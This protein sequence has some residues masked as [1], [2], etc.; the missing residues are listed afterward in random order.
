MLM[1]KILLWFEPGFE[2]KEDFFSKKPL[3]MAVDS[4]VLSG[5]D[6]LI[7][8]R[9]SISSKK[10][11]PDMSLITEFVEHLNRRKHVTDW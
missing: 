4:L 8:D 7:F 6:A 10:S 5:Y 11:R 1:F 3:I 9:R 2:S